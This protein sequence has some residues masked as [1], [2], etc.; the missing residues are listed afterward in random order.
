MQFFNSEVIFKNLEING[1]G[2]RGFLQEQTNEQKKEMIQTL[3]KE[4]AK[5]S[6][7]LPVAE[8]FTLERFEK[9]LVAN[10]HRDTAGKIIFN[11]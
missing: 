4:I 3:I 1:F 10:D 11:P 7:E 8:S 9:A 5:P 6:F 2:I